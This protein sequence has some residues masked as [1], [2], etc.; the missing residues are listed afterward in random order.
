MFWGPPH[1][2][3]MAQGWGLSRVLPLPS[4]RLLLQAPQGHRRSLL[5]TMLRQG[6]DLWLALSKC[7]EDIGKSPDMVSV[8]LSPFV[9]C[10]RDILG[11]RGLSIAPERLAP[12]R[13]TV[14]PELSGPAPSGLS[15]A[16]PVVGST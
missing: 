3:T 4:N 7:P 11:H 16:S 14:M 2:L 15:L 12:G 10:T 5:T 8:P 13:W 9:P 6:A 1:R